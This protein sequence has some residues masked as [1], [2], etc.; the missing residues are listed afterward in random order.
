MSHLHSDNGPVRP[1][2]KFPPDASPQAGGPAAKTCPRVMVGARPGQPDALWTCAQREGH[3]GPHNR[4]APSDG[5]TAW[6][7]HCS[8]CWEHDC[9]C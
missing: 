7:D 6:D 1:A 8:G 3:T 9:I 4:Y 5:C 2:F